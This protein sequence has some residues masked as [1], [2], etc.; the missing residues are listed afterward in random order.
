MGFNQMW[1]EGV[2]WIHFSGQRSV[3][4]FCED[5]NEPSDSIN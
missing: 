4:G 3:V 1:S 2:D 5:G